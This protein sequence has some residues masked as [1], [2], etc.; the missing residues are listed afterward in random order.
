[1]KIFLKLPCLLLVFC[2][3]A[4]SVAAAELSWSELARRPDLWPVQCTSKQAINFQKGVSIK[5]GQTLNVIQFKSDGVEVCTTDGRTIFDALPD[6]TDVLALARAGYAAL[7]PKQQELSYEALSRR[8]DLWPLRVTLL[9]TL[10]LGGGRI[11][12][13][14]DQ[15]RVVTVNR[16]S[17]T[18]LVEKTGATFNFAPQATDF[19]AQARK[20][21]EDESAGPRYVAIEQHVDEKT[22]IEGPV[23]SEMD[24]K[25]V[26]SV[27]NVP[28]P[29]DPAALPRYILFYRG[30]SKD[31]F[32]KGFTPKL[33]NYYRQMKP[34]HPEFEI[35]YLTT[36]PALATGKFAT[37][38][39]FS[40]R[41]V[42][43]ENLATMPITARAIGTLLPQIIVM[44]RAGNV[45]V[46]GMQT[47]ALVALERFD[48]ILRL[49]PEQN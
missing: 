16:G 2:G 49:P 48:A 46:N 1:M 10:D 30:S 22:R 33:V 9:K 39:G 3:L 5:A 27:T 6:E 45:L 23:I 8:Q 31:P 41:A 36:E 15:M 18:L 35:V 26:N 13:Q 47:S 20:F 32:T 44:D 25:L 28:A 29:F 38:M 14:G 40:W 24:G 11:L 19:L 4:A 17:L 34:L 7:T 37:K 12:R 42:T 21:V 43:D